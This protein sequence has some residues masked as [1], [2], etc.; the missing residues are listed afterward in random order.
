M[1]SIAAASAGEIEKK[2]ASK[3]EMS[4]WMKC[5]PRIGNLI[6]SKIPTYPCKRQLLTLSFFFFMRSE[7]NSVIAQR[8]S[9]IIFQNA[10]GHVASCG[11]LMENPH[12]AI[13]S[14]SL[15]S[16]PNSLLWTNDE[17]SESLGVEW[18]WPL[19]SLLKLELTGFTDVLESIREL[20]L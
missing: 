4:S 9:M 6:V 1:G 10:S 17:L 3:T 8:F 16:I 7:G 11:N 19:T 15:P 5:A 2:L 18:N 12:I 13:E 20:L 14:P